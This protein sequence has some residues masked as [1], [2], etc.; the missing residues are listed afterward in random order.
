M[1]E[2]TI[3]FDINETVLDLGVLKPKFSAA[4]G[5]EIMLDIWFSTLLHSS[6]VAMIT[7]IKTNFF[8]LAKQALETL[9]A[10]QGVYLS[11]S[12]IDDILQALSNLP[13]HADMHIALEKLRSAGFYIVAL[14]NSSLNLVAKQI[15][16]SGLS[17]YFD[18]V[19]SVEAFGS[20]KPSKDVYLQTAKKLQ[21]TPSNLRL[22]ATHD[23]DTHGALMAG[24]KAAYINRSGA[25]YNKLYEKPEIEGVSMLAIAEKIILKDK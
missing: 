3:L 21:K 18:E 9:A 13:P 22:I 7:G 11:A 25:L 16:N 17:E 14:S 6:T 1:K 4:F 12:S 20:F 23:W 5:D 24:L 19:I 15:E 10:K 8:N 2:T